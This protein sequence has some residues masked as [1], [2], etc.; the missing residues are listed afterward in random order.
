M[1]IAFYIPMVAFIAGGLFGWWM[2]WTEINNPENE[3]WSKFSK[4]NP[5]S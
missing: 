1:S 3:K 2:I 5:K 4:E